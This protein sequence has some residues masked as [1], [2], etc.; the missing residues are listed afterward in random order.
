MTPPDIIGNRGFLFSTVVMPRG[1]PRAPNNG[2]SKP[3]PVAGYVRGECL[4][5]APPRVSQL[6]RHQHGE[7]AAPSLGTR[8]RFSGATSGSS[9]ARPPVADTTMPGRGLPSR[10]VMP[11]QR[12]QGPPQWLSH[13]T[14]IEFHP[15]FRRTLA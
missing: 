15:P 5:F 10:L 9:T 12:L 7:P 8:S 2:R 14:H 11:A 3:P 13:L 4:P 6:R 1:R